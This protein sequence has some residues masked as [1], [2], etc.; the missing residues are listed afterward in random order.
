DPAVLNLYAGQAAGNDPADVTLVGNTVGNVQGSLVW[1][2]ASS[3]LSFIKTGSPLEPDDY[4]LTLSSRADG[5]V[6]LA[7]ALLDG[8]ADFIPGDDHVSSFSV[9]APTDR[10]V[11]FL[12]VVRGPRQPVELEGLGGIPI[13]IDDADGLLAVDFTFNFDPSQLNVT[14]VVR[15]PS[16][17]GDWSVVVNLSEPGQ[18]VVVASG[19]EPLPAGATDLVVVV[20]DVSNSAVY[21]N[22]QILEI[23]GLRLNE[24]QF[25]ARA[26]NALHQV[27]Y[28][29]DATGNESYSALDASLV[30]RVAV[31]LDS[32]FDNFPLTDPVLIADVTGNGS[33][34]ALDA[35]FISRKAVG[36]P[37]PEI[38][39]IPPELEPV[40]FASTVFASEQERMASPLLSTAAPVPNEITFRQPESVASLNVTGEN[41]FENSIAAGD[42]FQI[43]SLNTS[44]LG[45]SSSDH[46]NN[47]SM[48]LQLNTTIS[49]TDI[50]LTAVTGLIFYYYAFIA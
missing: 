36:L 12:D 19:T 48:G 32:G 10:L 26:D 28:F 47:F 40:F 22:A 11:H 15:A 43:M 38:P 3:T 17:P 45:R 46:V 6:D 5:I 14:D 2:A 42:K 33:L 20:A 41:G 16:L 30:A 31:G 1:D 13:R 8:N 4:L 37:Q 44:T 29:G 49:T 35:S 9:S 21:G 23:T 18:A 25:P 27:A 34:S 24:G 50:T 7:G 39:D